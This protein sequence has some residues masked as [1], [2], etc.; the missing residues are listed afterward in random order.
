MKV[1]FTWSTHLTATV[2]VIGDSICHVKPEGLSLRA[3]SLQS[4]NVDSNK[5]WRVE[6]ASPVAD[7]SVAALIQESE[8]SGMVLQAVRADSSILQF[9]VSP[10][11]GRQESVAL[12]QARK[13]SHAA[14]INKLKP[15]EAP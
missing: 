10:E 5:S 7:E 12:W 13:V 11:E 6:S 2:S 8:V 4:R 15:G 14:C 9:D 1:S 3:W